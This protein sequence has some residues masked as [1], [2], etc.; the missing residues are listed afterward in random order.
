M[1]ELIVT[2]KAIIFLSFVLQ[3]FFHNKLVSEDEIK[4]KI[5]FIRIIFQLN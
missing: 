2:S 1:V 3:I 4:I 5:K